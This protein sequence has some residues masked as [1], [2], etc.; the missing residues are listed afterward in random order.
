M[1]SWPCPLWP[2]HHD[3]PSMPTAQT[4]MSPVSMLAILDSV[5]AGWGDAGGGDAGGGEAGGGDAEPVGT[6]DEPPPPPQ[7]EITANRLATGNAARSHDDLRMEIPQFK[8]LR[9][10]DSQRPPLSPDGGRLETRR[11][12]Q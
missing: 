5:G 8:R 9:S 11:V 1:P 4:V 10:G 2:Q 12:G 7:A 6:D 3:C